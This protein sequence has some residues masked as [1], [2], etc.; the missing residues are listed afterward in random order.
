VRL[1]DG[2]CHHPT[3]IRH[4]GIG[5]GIGIGISVSV[6]N[7]NVSIS[8]ISVR[9]T[10]LGSN[11]V[12]NC[13]GNGNHSSNMCRWHFYDTQ[14]HDADHTVL[15]S[16]HFVDRDVVCAKCTHVASVVAT[17]LSLSIPTYLST[18]LSHTST[19]FFAEINTANSHVVV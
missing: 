17:T 16:V 1:D 2:D 6:S 14:C 8:N 10:S 7:S 15:L 4:T 5:I 9:S 19:P 3:H 11:R 12:G 18:F 13:N